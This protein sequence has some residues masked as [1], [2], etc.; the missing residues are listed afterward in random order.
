M[1]SLCEPYRDTRYT[2]QNLDRTSETHSSTSHLNDNSADN[3]FSQKKEKFESD[4]VIL[5]LL[6]QTFI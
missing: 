1:S 6:A 2:D 5:L 4:F 3:F